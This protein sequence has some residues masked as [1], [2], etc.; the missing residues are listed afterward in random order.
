MANQS[1]SD[2]VEQFRETG[3]VITMPQLKY[4]HHITL[5][6]AARWRVIGTQ[7]GLCKGTLD[8]IEHDNHHKAEACCNAVVNKWFEVDPYATWENLLKV[9]E[10]PEVSNNQLHQGANAVSLLSE[11]VRQTSM[12]TCFFVDEDIWP[13]YPREFTPL[14]LIYHQDQHSLKQSMESSQLKAGVYYDHRSTEKVS[15]LHHLNCHGSLNEV[16]NASKM[17]KQLTDILIPL[18]EDSDPQFILVEGPPGIGKSLLLR[19]ILLKWSKQQLLQKIKLLLL[20]QLR[21][22]DVQHV[23]FID[24]FLKLFCKRDKYG[25]EI[26]NASS[27]YFHKN[28]GKGLIF[29]FDG[30]DEFPENLQKDGLIAE[31]LKRE[32][33]PQCGIVVSSRPHAS[34]K[35]R[36]LATVKVN[37]LGFA[38]EER[39]QYIEQSLKGQ[40]HKIQELTEYLESHL[41]INGLCYIPFIMVALLYLYNKGIP[42]PSNPVD[43]YHCF[44]CLTIC[45]YLAKSGH[46]L[47]MDTTDLNSIPNPCNTIIKQLAKLALEALH[48]NKLTFTLE[49]LKT[50]CPG[51]KVI[52]GAING[53][54]ILQAVQQFGITST[55]TTFNFL[56]FSIQE[57]LA[58]YHVTQ[59]PAHQELKILQEYFWSDIHANM[60]CMYTKLTKAQ[61]PAF[62]QFLQQKQPSFLQNFKHIFSSDIDHSVENLAISEEFL[63]DQIKCLRLFH[64]FHDTGNEQICHYINAKSSCFSNKVMNLSYTSLYPYDLEC[65]TLFLANSPNKEWKK[66]NLCSCHVQDHGLRVLHRDLMQDDITIRELHLYDNNLT[67][68]SSSFVSDL[69]IHCRVE[70]LVIED[71]STIGEDPALY[72]MLSD[73]SSRLTELQMYR[74]SLTTHSAIVLFTALAKGNKLQLLDITHNNITDK[75]C[76]VIATFLKENSSLQR[77]WMWAN[78]ISAE[79]AQSLVHTLQQNNVLQGLGLPNFQSN[80]KKRIGSLQEEVNTNRGSRGCQTKLNIHYV[81]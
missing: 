7:L 15:M 62:K 34:S 50:A 45:Q 54:G 23:S 47:E 65:I 21:D 6:Y 63:K 70:V 74:T 2:G 8:I 11:R 10:S 75:A 20:L 41:T 37:I 66:L 68:L 52:P 42:L 69:T 59:L 28:H 44:I 76:E 46:P 13:P 38:E 9:I 1:V 49:E 60:F 26:S 17:T 56:H 81:Q 5:L 53:F 4:L 77:L 78:N 72:K 79:A 64:C 33:L 18:E 57:F 48:N 24:G 32:V 27:D 71:N 25:T 16:V 12:Q 43:L 36:Q 51:I 61:R 29:I 19:E 40:P 22:P 35:L 30:F 31:I 14:L 80:V 67:K 39:K 73:P 55:T 3:K 58:A